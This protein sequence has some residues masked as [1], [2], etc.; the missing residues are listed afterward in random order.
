MS[1]F[2]R[3]SSVPQ[4]CEGNTD[5][6]YVHLGKKPNSFSDNQN[7]KKKLKLDETN[8]ILHTINEDLE[9]MS[10]STTEKRPNFSAINPNHVKVPPVVNLKPGTT[11]KLVIKNFRSK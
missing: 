6:T 9:E 1:K 5:A 3:N 11:K 4:S 8:H 7:N 2:N 10:E